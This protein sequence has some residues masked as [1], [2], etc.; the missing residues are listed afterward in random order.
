[1]LTGKGQLT[2]ALGG[3]VYLIAWLFGSEP[4][5]PVGIGLV[6]AVALA[7][8]WVRVLARPTAVSRRF[9]DDARID[10]DDVDVRVGV[11]FARGL[12]AGSV[13]GSEL[14]EGLGEFELDFARVKGGYLARYQIEDTPRGRYGIDPTRVV[15]ADPFGF[16]ISE[17]ELTRGNSLLVYPRLVELQTLFSESSS[18]LADGRRLLLRRQT[19]YDLHS[20]R[21]YEQGESLRRVHWPTSARRGKLMV[22]ELEDAPRDEALV[23]LDAEEIA[24]RGTGRHSS[25]EVAV[26]AAGSIARAHAARGQR[27]GLLVNDRTREYQAVQSLEGDWP[28]ALELLACTKPTGRHPVATLLEEGAGPAANALDLTIVTSSLSARLAERLARRAAGRRGTAV[29]LIEASSFDPARRGKR[30]AELP[31]DVR[32]AMLRLARAGVP[33]AV[34]RKDDDLLE[35]LRGD[36]GV[37]LVEEAL[38]DYRAAAGV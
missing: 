1:M 12:P 3:L 34:I 22:K 17:T 23:I 16:A 21:E 20:V 6:V 37:E 24:V 30:E 19:G 29:V 9:G 31:V 36:E 2:L 5:Y 28:R 8:L 7:A 13:S 11:R 4:L 32:A 15:T 10:G 38:S 35:R 25:F 27:A 33:V 14:V 26:R 18:R